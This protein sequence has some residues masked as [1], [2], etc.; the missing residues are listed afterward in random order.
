M[1]KFL[2]EEISIKKSKNLRE[3]SNK[4]KFASRGTGEMAQG[5]RACN[6]HAEDLCMVL[7]TDIRLLTAFWDTSSRRSE[8]QA[9]LGIL[10]TCT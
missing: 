8:T 10:G 2:K 5:S 7:G 9:P 3:E 4:I 6:V 1:S